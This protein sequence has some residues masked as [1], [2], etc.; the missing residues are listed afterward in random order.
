MGSY[1]WDKWLRQSGFADDHPDPGP[2]LGYDGREI[3][4]GELDEVDTDEY[5]VYWQDP[6]DEKGWLIAT[7]MVVYDAEDCR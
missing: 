6:I 4:T 2:D 7:E 1:E 5:D 3:D